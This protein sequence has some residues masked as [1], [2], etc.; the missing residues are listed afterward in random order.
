MGQIL[1][2]LHHT[3]TATVQSQLY[4]RIIMD[5]HTVNLLNECSS[6][7]R[8]A[9]NSLKQLQRHAAAPELRNL[10]ESAVNK[11]ICLRNEADSLLGQMGRTGK[12]PCTG[13]ALFTWTM[14]EMK[15]MMKR[16]DNQVA[17]LIMDGCNMGIKTL[18]K[19]IRQ[20]PHASMESISLA[21][22]I[23]KTDENLLEEMKQY[24]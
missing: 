2:P 12:K 24:C 3:I 6:G 1:L 19:A 17:A 4:R 14:S 9:L 23:I 11:H 21:D 8:I 22:C 7:C 18:S 16:N 5:N 10:I 15:M 13:T 20:C